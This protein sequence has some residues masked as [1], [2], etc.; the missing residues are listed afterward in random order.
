MKMPMTREEKREKVDQLYIA[1]KKTKETLEWEPLTWEL[2]PGVNI[3]RKWPVI[4]AAYSGLEQTFKYL[5]AEEQGYTIPAPIGYTE[6]ETQDADVDERKK[7]PY[8]THNLDFLFSKLGKTPKSIVREFFGRFQ[9]LH[10]YITIES[11]DQ[12]LEEVSGP[13]GRG[14]E[15]WRYTLIEKKKLP[16]NSP[17][18]L[19]AI[20]GVCVDVAR[21]RIRKSQRVRMPDD[22]VRMPDDMLSQEFYYRLGGLSVAVSVERQNRGEEFQ[23]VEAEIQAWLG[24]AGHPL[25]AFADVLWHFDRYEIHGVTDISDCFSDTL[26]RWARRALEDPVTIGPATLRAFVERARGHWPDGASIRW[27]PNS[28]RFDALQWSLQTRFQDAPPPDAAIIGDPT[29][30]GTR[31]NTLWRAAREDGCR[32]LEN[33]AFDGPRDRDI[34]F[35]T[36]AV[37]VEEGEDVKPVLTVWEKR[38]SDE[39]LL[40]MVEDCPSDEI[41]ECLQ[42]WIDLA[43][44]IVKMRRE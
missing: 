25:N 15:E 44:S 22:L 7:Y 19:V 1:Q 34:W 24:K 9:S 28:N 2:H 39:N 3:A 6:P 5:I 30:Q 31:L 12:F 23:N 43:R 13:K 41:G 29:Y 21:E 26:T 38:W 27:N 4:I 14:Y 10:S 16:R 18:A 20:W 17:E 11:V 32:V 42:S 37:E 33:R 36:L 35:R 8:R 40:Y